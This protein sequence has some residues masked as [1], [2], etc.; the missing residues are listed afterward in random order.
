MS[1]ARDVIR[2]ARNYDHELTGSMDVDRL[3]EELDGY[4]T[5]IERLWEKLRL[6]DA[7]IDSLYA[8]LEDRPRLEGSSE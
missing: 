6:Y 5:K 2:V 1:Y 3:E 4:E 8:R 7:F